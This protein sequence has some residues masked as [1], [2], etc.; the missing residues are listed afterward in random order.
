MYMY[1]TVCV[2]HEPITVCT[3]YCTVYRILHGVQNTVQCT[4]YCTVY[5]ILYS[6]HNTVQ[7][8]GQTSHGKGHLVI[9]YEKTSKD[10]SSN[11]ILAICMTYLSML[12]NKTGIRRRIKT[13]EMAKVV[14][15]GWGKNLLNFCRASFFVKDDFE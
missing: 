6:V 9:L 8:A 2:L 7:C 12:V 14:A 13:E 5:R 3:E 10:D 4:E 1:G 11:S 15:D